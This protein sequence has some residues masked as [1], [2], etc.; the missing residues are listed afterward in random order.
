[1]AEKFP[2]SQASK[3]APQ[4]PFHFKHIEYKNPWDVNGGKDVHGAFDFGPPDDPEAAY[5][6][7]SGNPK[8]GGVM[9]RGEPVSKSGVEVRDGETLEQA[10]TR[11]REELL[12]P[13]ERAATQKWVSEPRLEADAGNAQQ[14][15]Q[16]TLADMVADEERERSNKL[17]VKIGRKVIGFFMKRRERKYNQAVENSYN[18]AFRAQRISNETNIN[19]FKLP[20][21][22][23][24]DVLKVAAAM[25]PQHRKRF[26]QENGILKKTS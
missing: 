20:E 25:D 7:Q 6:A 18:D 9:E 17:S 19:P 8:S 1:M 5:A 2:T 21:T 16:E 10:I 15:E 24:P 23:L 4:D 22:D 26:L 3:E 11:S 14:Q 12:T 13:A